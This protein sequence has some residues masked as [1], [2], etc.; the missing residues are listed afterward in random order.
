[1]SEINVWQKVFRDELFG[2]KKPKGRE[3]IYK[4][5]LLAKVGKTVMVEMPDFNSFSGFV[6]AHTETYMVT[7][8]ECD[9]DHGLISVMVLVSNLALWLDRGLTVKTSGIAEIVK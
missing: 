7:K 9:M 3:G 1:M 4:D 5:A 6:P 8:D 2:G